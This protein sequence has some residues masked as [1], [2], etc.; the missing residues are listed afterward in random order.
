MH[1][2][3]ADLSAELKCERAKVGRHGK[4]ELKYRGWFPGNWKDLALDIE[5]GKEKETLR[6]KMRF[7]K[8]RRSTFA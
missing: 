8:Q 6:S 5:G 7:G 4:S 2:S 1:P 3:K